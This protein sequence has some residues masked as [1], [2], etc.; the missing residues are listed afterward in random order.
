MKKVGFEVGARRAVC[1]D[2]P[3]GRVVSF[4]PGTRFEADPSN[5]SIVR[6]LRVG[7]IRRLDPREPLPPLP[8]TLGAPLHV[9][10]AVKARADIAATKQAR[11][12]AVN[13]Q[14][15]AQGASST[16]PDVA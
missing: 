3:D 6:L 7:E 16:P 15:R 8:P 1:V 14:T 9:R 4:P 13:N 5:P 2:F 11:K 10:N 12:A